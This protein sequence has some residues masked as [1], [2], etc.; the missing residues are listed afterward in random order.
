MRGTKFNIFWSVSLETERFSCLAQNVEPL[1]LCPR[2]MENCTP[3]GLGQS[4]VSSSGS[5]HGIPTTLHC[6]DRSVHT[7]GTGRELRAVTLQ[8]MALGEPRQTSQVWLP[9]SRT[10]PRHRTDKKKMLMDDVGHPS[11]SAQ[12][13]FTAPGGLPRST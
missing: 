3:Y 13:P 4:P 1:G 11:G 8:F 2:G 10:G 5:R 12:T 7:T 6:P 9:P